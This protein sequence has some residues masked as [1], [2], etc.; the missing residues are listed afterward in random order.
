M[1]GRRR[2]DLDCRSAKCWGDRHHR[3]HRSAPLQGKV[4]TVP[5]CVINSQKHE[6][7]TTFLVPPQPGLTRRVFSG[8]MGLRPLEAETA[9]DQATERPGMVFGGFEQGLRKNEDC[10][11]L[12][13]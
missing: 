2:G 12:K 7:E 8:S 1:G 10:P 11:F 5:V 13:V 9:R 3:Q 6:G 4:Q